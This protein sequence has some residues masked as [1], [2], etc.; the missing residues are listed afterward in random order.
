MTRRLSQDFCPNSKFGKRRNTACTRKGYAASVGQLALATAALYFS[1]FKLK[2]WGKKAA[3]TRRHNCA[4]LPKRKPERNQAGKR[5]GGRCR[6]HF[7]RTLAV[8]TISD[9]TFYTHCAVDLLR[10]IEYS[11]FRGKCE[12]NNPLSTPPVFSRFSGNDSNRRTQENTR[13]F[14]RSA[15]PLWKALSGL[16]DQP[17]NLSYQGGNVK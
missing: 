2:K 9:A 1:F 10:K 3:E 7:P 5:M 11:F 13:V 8:S 15:R 14:F 16:R 6:R 17:A 4:V 12:E